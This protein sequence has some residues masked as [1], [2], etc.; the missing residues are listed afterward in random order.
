MAQGGGDSI[1]P[2]AGRALMTFA[3]RQLAPREAR[4]APLDEGHR[5]LQK[6][7]AFGHLSLDLGLEVELLAHARVEPVVQL[8]LGPRVGAC[9]P[10]GQARGERGGLLAQASVWD[11]AVDQTPFEGLLR[12]QPL[13]EHRQLA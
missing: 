12:G 2:W 5:T 3:T 9:G 6:V 10:A 7:V 4:R 1:Q 8:A 13:P 11:D